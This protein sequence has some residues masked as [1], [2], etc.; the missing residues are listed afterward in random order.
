LS[1]YSL[2][3]LLYLMERLRDPQDG[4]PWDKKQTF[5][6]I[7]AHTLEESYELADAIEGKNFQQIKEELGD[8]LFQVVFYAQL[9][10]EQEV[11]QSQFNFS[12][13][14]N[15][16]VDKL[17]RRH[18]HVF[19][20]GTL[21]SRVGQQVAEITDIKKTWESIK[22]QERNYKKQLGVLD[23]IPLALPAL[24]RAAKL[25][26]RASQTGFDWDQFDKVLVQLKAEIDELL[27][28]RESCSQQHISEEMGDVLFSAV[29]LA[30]HLKVDPETA[31]RSTNRKFE[32]RFNYIEQS[33]LSMG[34]SLAQASLEKMDDLWQ[35]AKAKG[36]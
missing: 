29:N 5:E 4:C 28:A 36:L 7:I 3:D 23:D 1:H 24:T 31:L 8:V 12:D 6:S 21:S 25:Q 34:S 14:V 32:A 27:E 30:R 13:I 26:K 15:I 19:P 22:A 2:D 11:E 33:L 10:K 35:E 9:G 20:A 17:L 18:P 16:L